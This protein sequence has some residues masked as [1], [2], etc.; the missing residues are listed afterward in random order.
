M[1]ARSPGEYDRGVCQ[2]EVAR[3]YQIYSSLKRQYV[4]TYVHDILHNTQHMILLK[5]KRAL[6]QSRKGFV[7]YHEQLP[8]FLSLLDERPR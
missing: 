3:A 5:K 7:G 1:N 4:T 8:R 2:E 6:T